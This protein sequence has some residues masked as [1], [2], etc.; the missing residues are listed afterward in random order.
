MLTASTQP[1]LICA[2]DENDYCPA[3]APNQN[4]YSNTTENQSLIILSPPP[5]PA[6]TLS[7]LSSEDDDGADSAV[8]CADH[9]HRQN[10]RDGWTTG[11]SSPLDGDGGDDSLSHSGVAVK[12]RRLSSSL[13]VERI[14]EL[15][16][17]QQRLTDSVLALSTHFAHIQFR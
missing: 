14:R 2:S 15:E 11:S 8:F 1:D 7:L 13:S 5:P 9:R 4:T 17:E 6:P 3:S 16:E 10:H 12:L